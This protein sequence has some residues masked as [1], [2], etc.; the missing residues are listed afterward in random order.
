MT[1][2]FFSKDTSDDK[3]G[4]V[5]EKEKKKLYMWGKMHA[6]YRLVF[7]APEILL[8]AL[9]VPGMFLVNETGNDL[10]DQPLGPISYLS[11]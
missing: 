2:T 9:S 1:N 6:K 8:D 3:W 10:A 7:T 5:D 4:N 11:S